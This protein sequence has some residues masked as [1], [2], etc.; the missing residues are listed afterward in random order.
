[1]FVFSL[2]E[3]SHQK[4]PVSAMPSSQTN[5]VFPL[6]FPIQGLLHAMVGEVPV[7]ALCAA[8]KGSAAK[9]GWEGE[10]GL[11]GALAELR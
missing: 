7:S 5:K 8:G 6:Q 2:K 4:F 1:M 9:W 11:E 3:E 10:D